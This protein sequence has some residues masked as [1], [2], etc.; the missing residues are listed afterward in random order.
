MREFPISKYRCLL[1]IRIRRNNPWTAIIR[2][3]KALYAARL[4]V[5]LI[6]FRH[7]PPSTVTSL[8]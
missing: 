1:K 3:P 5:F 7:I 8:L 6:A 2:N 4:I